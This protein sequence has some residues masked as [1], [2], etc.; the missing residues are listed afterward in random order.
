MSYCI[1]FL[2][3][4]NDF[5]RTLIGSEFLTECAFF[6]ILYLYALISARP[7]AN[8]F[9][10]EVL[11]F[12]SPCQQNLYDIGKLWNFYRCTFL[13]LLMFSNL[14]FMLKFFTMMTLIYV[15][16]EL[17]MSKWRVFHQNC[18]MSSDK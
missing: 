5:W 17:I 13:L 2:H 14:L 7:V 11:F 18:D 1:S 16:M 3:T 12:I 8:M 9:N 10:S 15:H 4:S 6:R